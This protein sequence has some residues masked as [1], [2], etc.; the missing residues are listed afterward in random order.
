MRE[1][2]GARYLPWCG[3]CY[4]L[5]D[6]QNGFYAHLPYDGGYLD[7]GAITMQVLDIIKGEFCAYLTERNET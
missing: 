3:M 6:N 1:A 2:G 7:Q 5:L 4:N